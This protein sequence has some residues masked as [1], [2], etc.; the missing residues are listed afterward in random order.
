M[1]REVGRFCK[2]VGEVGHGTRIA[3][4]IRA[5][6]AGHD[7]VFVISDM[8]TF[9]STG[10]VTAAVA[11]RV[12]LYGFNLGGYRR[13]AYDA[14]STNRHE[15]GGLTDATFQMIPLI[16]AGRDAAWPF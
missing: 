12:P 10:E 1:I 11:R 8:Q 16:E 9:P 2:R 13:T 6:F 15:F 5:T 3:E 4:S 14:G 7:R